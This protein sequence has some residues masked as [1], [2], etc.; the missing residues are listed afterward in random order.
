V[1]SLVHTSHDIYLK[2]YKEGTT[3]NVKSIFGILVLVL[4][5]GF[6]SSVNVFAKGI[7]GNFCFT[8]HITENE[9][10]PCDETKTIA[11][12]IKSVDASSVIMTGTQVTPNQ[13]T[14]FFSGIG[15]VAGDTIT[16]N[17]SFTR[18]ALTKSERQAGAMQMVLDKFTL[19]GSFWMIA[20][21]Y[22]TPSEFGNG[23][24]AGTITKL[25]KCPK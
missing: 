5:I 19:S 7:N 9:D 6:F 8:A 16:F 21:A 12:H 2:T 25:P 3:M 20:Q 4:M 11:A 1:A 17:V 14:I 18:D 23:Y 13:G 10:G 24:N 15:Q 22:S